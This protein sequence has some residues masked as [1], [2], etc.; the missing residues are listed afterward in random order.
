[1]F[2]AQQRP[3]RAH[4]QR[5]LQFDRALHPALGGVVELDAVAAHPHVFAAQRGKPEA[6][7]LLRVLL[8]ARA[9]VPA[10]EQPMRDREHAGTVQPAPAQIADHHDA[11]VRQPLRQ[12]Q[13]PVVL[14]LGP[15]LL[16]PL[17]VQVLLAA[18]RV[19]AD[20]LDVAV[21]IR[22]DPDALPGRRDDEFFDARQGVGLGRRGAVGLE[23]GEA[24]APA[25]ASYAGATDSGSA[26][27]H[28]LGFST[29]IYA[30][31]IAV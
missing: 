7:V 2:R 22:A 21:G 20:G 28:G 9:K 24:A 13:R 17:V 19:G 14:L 4:H 18:R 5:I 6:A 11:P 12:A 8:T 27:P 25:D 15:L 10:V 23:I 3:H 31:N 16:P 29:E 1:M 26:Q 30:S